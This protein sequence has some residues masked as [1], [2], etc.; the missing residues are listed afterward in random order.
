MIIVEPWREFQTMA[1]IPVAFS[2]SKPTQ[3]GDNISMV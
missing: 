3:M 1:V 2:H